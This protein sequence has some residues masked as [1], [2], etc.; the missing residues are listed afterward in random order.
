M[1]PNHLTADIHLPR[2]T[3]ALRLALGIGPGT[4]A[5]LGPSGSGKSTVLRAIAGLERPARGRIALGDEIWFDAERRI[6]LAPERRSV[7]MVMQDLALFPHL[8]A[9]QNVGF[10]SP[11]RA[12][13]LMARFGITHL[14][15]ARPALLSGGERQ[16]VALARAIARDPR[17]LLL[18]EPLSALDA[19]TR[20]VVRAELAELLDDLRL[21]TVLVT[22][23]FEDAAIL[24]GTVIVVDHGRIVQSGT[25]DELVSRPATPLVARLTGAN[26]VAGTAERAPA[27]LTRVVLDDG[28][29]VHSTDTATGRVGVAVQPVDIAVAT[30]S[31]EGSTM[32]RVPG[33]VGSV[34]RV[35]NRA[36]VRVGGLSAEITVASLDRLGLRQGDVAVAS[37][38]ATATR[39]VTPAPGTTSGAGGDHTASPVE[40]GRA[41]TE[42][43][44]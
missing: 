10:A 31:Q 12:P 29:V 33:R 3:F 6:A 17:V 16:R 5:V 43:R 24:A 15:D 26:L 23:D 1:E 4:A 30:R 44:A 25:P 21:T 20:G 28:T 37:F 27:G 18:D 8:T 41:A 22:H 32:N 9:A 39:L 14:A 42:V 36:R 35:G 13:E 7:S 11:R 19:D 40:P 34:V 38:K 2:R